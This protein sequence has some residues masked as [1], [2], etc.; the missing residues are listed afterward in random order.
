[1]NVELHHIVIFVFIYKVFFLVLSCFEFKNL[2]YRTML[3]DKKKE[4]IEYFM[5]EDYYPIFFT[6]KGKRPDPSRTIIT[7]DEAEQEFKRV[8]GSFPLFKCKLIDENLS[9]WIKSK[10]LYLKSS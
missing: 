10:I 1:M 7:K 4:E 3:V 8:L 2:L 6:K 9:K 5:S